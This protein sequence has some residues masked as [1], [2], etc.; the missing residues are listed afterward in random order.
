MVEITYG[1]LEATLLD[2]GFV[3]RESSRD[4]RWFEHPDSGAVVAFPAFPADE[5]I[6]DRHHVMVGAILEAYGYPNPFA[7][8]GQ[9]QYAKEVLE[10]SAENGRDGSGR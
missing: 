4:D 7:V 6:L 3:R 9:P 1:R 5:P 10:L 8:A 2:L